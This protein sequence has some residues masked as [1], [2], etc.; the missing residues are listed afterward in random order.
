[1]SEDKNNNESGAM[2]EAQANDA[3]QEGA[4]NQP[5]AAQ[6]KP[7]QGFNFEFD[8]NFDIFGDEVAGADEPIDMDSVGVD[9]GVFLPNTEGRTEFLPPDPE[10]VPKIEH[11]IKQD[12]PEY[13]ERPAI[14]RTRELFAYM[15]PHRIMLLQTLE[16]ATDIT[17]N[18]EMEQKID[19]IRAHKFSVYSPVNICTMLEVAGALERVTADGDPYVEH[20][21]KPDI[22]IEDGE[23]F[24]VPTNPE[25]VYWHISA[26]G[27]QMLED[28][29]LDTKLKE[30][31]SAD[32]KY[33]G[34]YKRV[35]RMANAQDGTTMKE[36]SAAVDGDPLISKPN[37][38][39]F[40]QHYVET[41]ERC[42]AISWNGSTWKLTDFG[43]KYFESEFADIQETSYV[44]EP[45]THE[46]TDGEVL[47]ESQGVC[48]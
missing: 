38:I 24:Y 21:A 29:D 1:M 27:E 19:E 17:S 11:A 12:S 26:A 3:A 47:T 2:Q 39:H 5:N 35:M 46:G 4:A 43:K 42:E 41:L 18:E 33:L 36:L 10:K 40:V 44:P 30:Q 6:E 37:R 16:A 14:E 15:Y 48:W 9:P 34:I 8:P 13:A 7:S 32:E 28:R 22:V 31:L 45:K 20:E 25:P 23:E